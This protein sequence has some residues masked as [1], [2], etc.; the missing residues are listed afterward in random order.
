ML[1]GEVEARRLI[2]I[3]ESIE[4]MIS[5]KGNFAE[6]SILMVLIIDAGSVQ[7][8]YRTVI[9]LLNPGS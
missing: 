9:M 8:M 5:K 1:I 3:T 6:A 7:K 2:S 4:P